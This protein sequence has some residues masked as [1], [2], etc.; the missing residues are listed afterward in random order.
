MAE[1]GC[2]LHRGNKAAKRSRADLKLL[3][4]GSAGGAQA[5]LLLGGRGAGGRGGLL[6]PGLG[7]PQHLQHQSPTSTL[8][9]NI[10]TPNFLTAQLL[11]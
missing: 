5:G 2:V 1:T 10:K 11:I 8:I 3:A 4:G 9:R 6:H 7:L